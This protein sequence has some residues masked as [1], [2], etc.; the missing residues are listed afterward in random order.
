MKV[1]KTETTCDICGDLVQRNRY[2]E[3]AYITLKGTSTDCI[4]YL[5][6]GTEDIHSAK[7]HI[8]YQCLHDLG[9]LVK[10]LR[11]EKKKEAKDE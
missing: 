1:T 2:A 6:W 10:G 9:T 7:Y 4:G 5:P 3:K 8:C 11:E